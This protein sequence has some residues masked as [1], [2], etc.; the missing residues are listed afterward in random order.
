MWARFYA[1]APRTRKG[2]MMSRLWKPS[3]PGIARPRTFD[4][5]FFQRFG[6]DTHGGVL[7][8]FAI[9]LPILLGV[10][11]LSVDIGSW[12]ASKRAAQ[13]A[14]DAGAL[15]AALEVKRVNQS[16]FADNIGESAIT[17]IATASAS[18]NGY[19]YGDGDTIEVN[20]PPKSGPNA[21]TAGAV[22]VIVRQP[23]TVFLARILMDK[24]EIT[25]AARAVAVGGV[26]NECLY[27]LSEKGSA[28]S[29]TGGAIVNLPC[30]IM[31]N[32]PDKS[33]LAEQGGSCITAASV[34][35]AGG[36]TGDCISP[37][38]VTGM[39]KV[40]DPFGAM[41]APTGYGGCDYNQPIKVNSGDTVDLD[42]GVYCGQISVM[43]G[44][45]LNFNEG[46]YVLDTAGLNVA[47]DGVVNG[48]DVTFYLT[49][50]SGQ[51]D[52]INIS[53]H[54]QVALS[55]P[56]DGDLPGVL[57]YQDRNS[58][59]NISHNFTGQATTSLKGI[60]YFPNQNIKFAGGSATDPVPTIIVA[61][62]VQFT[63]NTEIGDP[64]TPL[65]PVPSPYMI[66]VVLVE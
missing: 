14:A 45:T 38:A 1:K 5:R 57:F 52:N 24:A 41:P 55:A 11:G 2:Q 35:T 32:S 66:K 48:S 51:G 39:P 34:K 7:I 49:E 50:D 12:Y 59:T 23:A 18:E 22:E 33:S 58:P 61:D 65:D 19:D 60:L 44:G 27:A 36:A 53:A 10:S 28:V 21:G 54:A 9:V 20:F 43:S 8:Y 13:A 17:V 25:V 15:A 30:G 31:S 29:A 63:G 47:S 3:R 16:S 62:T 42:P 37:N 26:S 46:L 6:K 64:D 40:N 4:L 56:S